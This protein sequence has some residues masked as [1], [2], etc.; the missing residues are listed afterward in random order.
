M[1]FHYSSFAHAIHYPPPLFRS[2]EVFGSNNS[3]A[4]KMRDLLSSAQSDSVPKVLVEQLGK[5]I[6]DVI[7]KE[8]GCTAVL[9]AARARR[10]FLDLLYA[11]NIAETDKGVTIRSRRKTSCVGL[12]HRLVD[13]NVTVDG[14]QPSEN[15]QTIEQ[16]LLDYEVSLQL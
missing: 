13:W 8:P 1:S 5:R 7:G 15:K 16:M 3:R 14:L 6:S 2:Q 11:Q 12:E 9:E 10:K 4:T